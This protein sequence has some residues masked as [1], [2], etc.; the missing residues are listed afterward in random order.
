M[1]AEEVLLVAYFHVPGAPLERPLRMLEGVALP[2]SLRAEEGAVGVHH[3]PVGQDSPVLVLR[4]SLRIS[5]SPSRQAHASEPDW[6]PA[7]F[8]ALN[9]TLTTVA[10]AGRRSCPGAPACVTGPPAYPPRG[11][12]CRPPPSV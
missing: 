3:H 6:V 12:A 8:A 5:V 10:A 11:V 9:G 4:V 2:A 1:T 7:G